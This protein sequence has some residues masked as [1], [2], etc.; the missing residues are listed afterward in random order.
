MVAGASLAWPCDDGSPGR[1][2]PSFYAFLLASH[3]PHNRLLR[4]IAAIFDFTTT[5]KLENALDLGAV[6]SWLGCVGVDKS[7]AAREASKTTWSYCQ[8]RSKKLRA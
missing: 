2:P 6:Y 1:T 3:V 4:G 7:R 8:R 5:R